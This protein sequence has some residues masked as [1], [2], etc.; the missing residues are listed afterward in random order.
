MAGVPQLA[1]AD[2]RRP[3]AHSL[4]ADHRYLTLQDKSTGI[5]QRVGRRV[6]HFDN[7]ESLA[8]SQ[9]HME[10]HLGVRM[11]TAA[12]VGNNDPTSNIHG[13]R[14]LRGLGP[15]IV[16][17]TLSSW[18][19]VKGCSDTSNSPIFHI[20]RAEV[21]PWQRWEKVTPLSFAP[22]VQ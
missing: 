5:G 11:H 20:G 2:Q 13:A 15:D 22:N 18:C 16:T 9:R 14:A 10:P 3:T 12:H 4:R 7:T 1:R 8:G 19:S 21:F 6:V 17:Y